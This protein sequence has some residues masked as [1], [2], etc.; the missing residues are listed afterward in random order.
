MSSD[1][2][3]SSLLSKPQSHGN[4][5]C[6]LSRTRELLFNQLPS[7]SSSISAGSTWILKAISMY[8]LALQLEDKAS[9][10]RWP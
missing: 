9:H 5:Y 2:A 8:A 4:S 7:F 3:G 10:L 6:S 1:T